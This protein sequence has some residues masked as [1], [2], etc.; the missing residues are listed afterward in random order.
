MGRG[1]S[2]LQRWILWLA[3]EQVSVRPLDILDGWYHLPVRQPVVRDHWRQI[4]RYLDPTGQ[5]VVD[6]YRGTLTSGHNIQTLV[7]Q[8]GHPDVAG[9]GRPTPAYSW[10]LRR[11][12]WMRSVGPLP[13]ASYSMVRAMS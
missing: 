11:A 13:T 2:E 3:T 5:E 9:P 12:A 8:F 4:Y 6:S 7:A 10:V 1:L